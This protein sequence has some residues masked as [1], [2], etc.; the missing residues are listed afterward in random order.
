MTKNASAER[1]VLDFDHDSL[2]HASNWPADFQEMR[3]QCPVAWSEHHG[4]FWIVTRYEDVVRVAQDN[5]TF[6]SHKSYDPE[7]GHTAGGTLIP[8]APG[9]RNLPVESD[10]PEWDS[11]RKLIN[12]HFGPKAAEARREAAQKYAAALIDRVIESGR[13]DIVNDFTSPLPAIMTMELLGFPLSEWRQFADPLHEMI[14]CQRTDPRYPKV[15]ESVNWVHSRVREVIAER[16]QQPADD[17]ISH[18]VTTPIDGKLLADHTVHEFCLNILLGGV[19]TTTALTSNV[20]LYLHRHPEEK[21]RLIENPDLIPPAREEFLRFFSP[22]HALARTV[23]KDT[24]FNGQKMFKGERVLLPFSS[25]NRDPKVFENPEQVVL[26]RHPN[27]HVGF[28]AGIHRCVG[29]FLARV[30]FDSMLNAWLRRVPDYCVD[31]T[32]TVPYTSVGVVNGWV[33]MPAT[34]TPGRKSGVTIVL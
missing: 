5:E 32:A 18:F 9:P 15:I 12:P 28:G 8:P 23:S 3:E 22:I 21:R 10:R 26:D 16:R 13:C 30:A 7:T 6:S 19:D 17:L 33:N 27:R 2:Q 20:L 14:F 11:L 31:L 34:F 24:V 25:A 29:S 4:G 1:P